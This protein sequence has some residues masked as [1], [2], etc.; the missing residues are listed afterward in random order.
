[1]KI[2]HF[3]DE[4]LLPPSQ[5]AALLR[6]WSVVSKLKLPWPRTTMP[7]TDRSR[8]LLNTSRCRAPILQICRATEVAL[9]TSVR[10][11]VD[12]V[13]DK[14]YLRHAFYERLNSSALTTIS[15][16]RLWRGSVNEWGQKLAFSA[17]GKV[18]SR[19][20]GARNRSS[21]VA[22]VSK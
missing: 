21:T 19:R 3:A 10:T 2:A 8:H 12:D 7:R 18:K 5:R 14:T 17:T 11:Y 9:F 15:I 13:A 20:G 1:M 6:A 4:A 16:S 22:P